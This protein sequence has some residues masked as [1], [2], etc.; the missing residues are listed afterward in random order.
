[1]RL[2]A[3]VEQTRRSTLLIAPPPD[4]GPIPR[5]T[6]RISG[7]CNGPAL[8]DPATEAKTAFWGQW[9]ITVHREPP[10][11]CGVC[12]LHTRPGGLIYRWTV[13]AR[14]VV[15]TPSYTLR[16]PRRRGRQAMEYIERRT[17]PLRRG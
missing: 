15:T 5:N 13:S 8:F 1:M 4:I 11:L 10:G 9:S 2:T 17:L 6:H 12:K 14:S 7:M 3:S 16:R